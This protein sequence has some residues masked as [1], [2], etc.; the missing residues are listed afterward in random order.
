MKYYVFFVIMLFGYQSYGQHK[1]LLIYDLENNSLDSLTN[2]EFDTTRTNDKTT[3]FIG[4][5]DESIQTLAQE[6]PGT[7]IYPG[8][9]FTRK[10]QAAL[11][12]D[13]TK[14]PL[15]TNSKIF[16]ALNDTL[17]DLCSGSLISRKHVLTAAHCVSEILTSTLTYDS[18]IVCPAFNNGSASSAFPCSPVRKVYIFKGWNFNGDDFAL[19]ELYD[20]IGSITGWI[21]IGF[22]AVDSTLKQ[23]IFYKFSY[24]AQTILQIDSNEYNGDTL[25]YSYG[26]T[27][28]FNEKFI[29][30]EYARAIP[31]ESGSSI[32]KVEN[33]TSYT[34][35]GVLSFSTNL[36]H[37]RLSNW[38]YYYLESIIHQ[39]LI[40]NVG[41]EKGKNRIVL[42]PNP[43][44]DKIRIQPLPDR[45]NFEVNICNIYGQLVMS[46]P[47]NDV[48]SG[49]DIRTL[50]E[51]IY[52]V[53]LKTTGHDLIVKKMT[54]RRN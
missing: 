46:L 27:D 33:E 17:H 11:D 4:T 12:Y 40:Y 39:D 29:G 44:D 8:S 5:I 31:G 18:L 30:V 47:G 23:G 7:N 21:S 36:M 42:F 20:P 25:Y 1:T 9:Q 10:R 14:Y 41:E 35:Y 32:I 43:A 22:N 50:S 38:S 3:F 6:A 19:L 53:I 24:P 34:S 16:Y 26:I 28:L 49:I 37:S 13:L 51:G 52:F 15:R 54:I 48:N 2:L 45:T